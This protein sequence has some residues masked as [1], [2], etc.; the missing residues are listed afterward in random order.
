MR[1]TFL[2]VMLA[3]GMAGSAIGQAQLTAAVV[4][5]ARVTEIGTPVTVFSTMINSGDVEAT[6][7]RVEANPENTL[8]TDMDYQRTDAANLPIGTANTPFA[9]SAGGSQSLVLTIRPQGNSG[10][11]YYYLSYVCNGISYTGPPAVSNVFIRATDPAELASDIIMTLVTLSGDGVMRPAENGRRAVAA[12]AA[13]NIG[14]D[15]EIEFLMGYPGFSFS[16]LIDTRH[17]YRDL[18]I[19]LTDG[20]SQCIDPPAA[21]VRRQM[22]T[23]DVATFNV[24]FDDSADFGIP[25]WPDILRVTAEA[26]E[27]AQFGPPSF[28]GATSVGITDS[29]LDVPENIASHGRW[30]GFLGDTAGLGRRYIDILYTP[31]RHIFMT[32]GAP[33]QPTTP[34]DLDYLIGSVDENRDGSRARISGTLQRLAD[35][36]IDAVSV[37]GLQFLLGDR[38]TGRANAFNGERIRALP[39]PD[40]FPEEAV[41]LTRA[42]DPASTQVSYLL[43]ALSSDS[44][45][46]SQGG[47]QVT[48]EDLIANMFGGQVFFDNARNDRCV[49]D[50][51]IAPNI[52]PEG[53][54]ASHTFIVD[55][56][57]SDCSNS[58]IGREG[59]Y[60]GTAI[61]TY[62]TRTPLPG[63]RPLVYGACRMYAFLERSGDGFTW[64]VHI[65]SDTC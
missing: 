60:S 1:S 15:Q 39:L 41:G 20:Q 7:C 43:S 33:V 51:S 55:I 59:N 30:I 8:G 28:S 10:S 37:D 2:A 36:S 22:N 54:P 64:P 47:F 45:P 58:A 48:F 18:L 19:C 11:E 13:I 21:T 50:G 12:G 53:V 56:T 26:W 57:L 44:T 31:D 4:P 14:D 6:N 24:Y 61:S 34:L 23:N 62:V 65:R 5:N 25:F 52:P 40:N 42:R 32:I 35:G 16:P 3:A 63:E 38:A 17:H 29:G 49:M 46:L 27:P 9:I